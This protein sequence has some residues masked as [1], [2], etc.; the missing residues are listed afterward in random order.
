MTRIPFNITMPPTEL[1]CRT[2]TL[3][4]P[5]GI[6][7]ISYDIVWFPRSLSVPEGVSSGH[8]HASVVHGDL[9]RMT[10]D[11][12]WWDRRGNTVLPK[13]VEGLVYYHLEGIIECL[14]ALRVHVHK[15]QARS[16]SPHRLDHQRDRQKYSSREQGSNP[17]CLSRDQVLSTP[18]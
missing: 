8:D 18:R 13:E 15:V 7:Y 17:H 6:S 11:G 3:P 10:E 1:A 4:H 5:L 2:E 14:I 9:V 16:G 12:F